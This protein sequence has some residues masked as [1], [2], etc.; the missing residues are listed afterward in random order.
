MRTLQEQGVTT[1][2]LI[3]HH[4]QD[5]VFISHRWL[6]QLLVK[7]PSSRL[8]FPQRRQ[9]Q[10]GYGEFQQSFQERESIITSQCPDAK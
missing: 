9:A 1:K 7:A 6:D 2:G 5:P 4:D 10:H 8:V 3:A